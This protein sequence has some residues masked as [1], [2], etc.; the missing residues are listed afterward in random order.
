VPVVDVPGETVSRSAY[1]QGQ[2]PTPSRHS[3][4]PTRKETP[5]AKAPPARS[6][7]ARRG[8]IAGGAA[9]AAAGV[10]FAAFRLRQRAQDPEGTTTATPARVEPPVVHPAPVHP[11][12]PAPSLPAVEPSA[13]ATADAA[14]PEGPSVADA[15]RKPEGRTRPSRPADRSD[16]RSNKPFYQGTRLEIEKKAPY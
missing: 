9:L 6:A 3:E 11:T 5:R 10:L 12:S 4:R 2:A 1:D 8:L 16:P 15:P 13:V 14:A 7:G